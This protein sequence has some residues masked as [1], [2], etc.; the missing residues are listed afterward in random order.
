M[1]LAQEKNLYHQKY[2]QSAR[3]TTCRID[4]RTDLFH[5][6][7]K[8]YASKNYRKIL[9]SWYSGIYLQRFIH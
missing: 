6:S 2:L 7:A 5:G 3:R 8:Y 1:A 4:W 9:W